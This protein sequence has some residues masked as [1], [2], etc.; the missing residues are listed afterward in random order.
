MDL[1]LK[2]LQVLLNK[3]LLIDVGYHEIQWEK[4]QLALMRGISWHLVDFSGKR[5]VYA[6]SLS[7]PF[8]NPPIFFNIKFLFMYYTLF[9]MKSSNLSMGK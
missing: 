3:S 4:V 2:Y 5:G 7:G 8:Q 6:N 1:H 9:H